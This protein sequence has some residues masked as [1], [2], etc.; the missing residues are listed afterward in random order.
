MR[1]I[2]LKHLALA[3][4]SSALL[5]SSFPPFDYDLAA[6][7]C[8]VPLLLILD[9]TRRPSSYVICL[10]TGV[11][12]FSVGV[13]GWSL[14]GFNTLDYSLLILYLSQYIA[15]WGVGYGWIRRKTSLP[16]AV[17]APA[18]W[19]LCEY[20]RSH[21]SFLSLPWLLLGHSQY[22]HPS[23]IQIA[24][25]TGV[26]GLS[27]II[28][29]SNVA[30]AEALR[31]LVSRYRLRDA[32]HTTVRSPSL[33]PLA[34]A[35]CLLLLTLWYGHAELSS[36]T[37]REGEAIRIGIVQGNVPP[38]RAWELGFRQEILDRYSRLTQD[39]A[40]LH[41]DLIVWPET[42]VPGDVIHE[43]ELGRRVSEIAAQ[44]GTYLL[45][46]SSQHAKFFD[47]GL[48]DKDFNSMVLFGPDGNILGEY[49]KMELVPFGE[50]E[51]LKGVIQWPQ[52]I[53]PIMGN[54]LPG[55]TYT[56]FSAGGVVFGAVICWESIFPEH[57]RQFINRGARF[58]VS[59]SNESWFGETAAPH[60][61]LA[62]TV[63]RAA[64][65]KIAIVKVANTGISAV[66]D[67]FGRIT[68]RLV[69]S[70]GKELFT[71]GVMLVHVPLPRGS[72]RTLYARYGDSF[73]LLLTVGILGVSC[74]FMVR[75]WISSQPFEKPGVAKHAHRGSGTERKHVDLT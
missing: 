72:V 58:M 26:Y 55:D 48:R 19:I 15:V 60:Q 34:L 51:P 41:P 20:G 67:P 69:D 29:L 22:R 42:S 18:L 45:V 54:T 65:N 68:N 35:G 9:D 59:A 46:G 73:M 44:A 25:F 61:L 3:F 11:L 50:Y 40:R 64:E 49:R 66:I 24:D 27:F 4:L 56:L 16:S 71:E 57:Y 38:M 37:E 13:S 21:A 1:N 52:S 36:G 30:V 53:A 63:F 33:L 39:V 17:V 14:P 62:I 74:A 10:L 75:G 43:P 8:L 6:W 28:V 70:H 31:V 23:L 12:F 5:V 47:P 32:M 7:V 2:G